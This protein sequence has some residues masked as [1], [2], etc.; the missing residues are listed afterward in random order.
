MVVPK[1]ATSENYPFSKISWNKV[2]RTGVMNNMG[3]ALTLGTRL[4][5]VAVAVL[6]FSYAAI[7]SRLAYEAR[8]ASQLL[9]A[10]QNVN[11]GDS[12]DSIRPILER[13]GGN[14]WDKQ[15]GS[16]ED[17]SYVLQINPWRFPMLS[18]SKSNGILPS[19]E[20]TLNP[21][22][23]RAVG[24][25]KWMVVS[26]IAIKNNRV[27]GVNATTIVEGKRM[28]LGAMSRFSEKPREFE[29]SADFVGIPSED[30]RLTTSGILDMA[31]GGGT[32]WSFWTS[33][34]APRGQRQMANQVNFRCLRSLSGCDTVCDLM[35]EAAQFFRN[36]PELAPAGGGWDDRQLTCLKQD[37]DS[38]QYR[39]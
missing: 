39:P 37:Q 22:F 29:R 16:N 7:W 14:R 8:R 30:V 13:Y 38:D 36:H 4:L 19:I 17:Y 6:L 26:D 12:E 35:P 1:M 21:R 11:V 10:V 9:A 32:S 2:V 5:M 34:S 25:R 15:L 23:R 28:W 24:I 33:P 3:R 20:P 27:V 18:D 31:E